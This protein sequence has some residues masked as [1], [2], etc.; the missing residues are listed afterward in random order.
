MIIKSQAVI[1]AG[2]LGH[3][4]F[5]TLERIEVNYLGM[6]LLLQVEYQAYENH[7]IH[8]RSTQ[9]S[10]VHTDPIAYK[11]QTLFLAC[12][13]DRKSELKLFH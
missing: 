1:N 4:L 3:T 12:K 10:G 7:W 2:Q 11:S 5:N 13:P 6:N 8:V 9:K